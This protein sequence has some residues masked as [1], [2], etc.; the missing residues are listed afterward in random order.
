MVGTAVLCEVQECGFKN[1]FFVKLIYD[2]IGLRQN[3]F[4]SQ[5][6]MLAF[7]VRELHK[8]PRIMLPT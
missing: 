7:D 1:I 8:D 5:F 3:R 6:G 4:A 2:F